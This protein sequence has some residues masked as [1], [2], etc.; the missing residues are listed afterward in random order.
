VLSSNLVDMNGKYREESQDILFLC[1]FVSRLWS[2]L[3]TPVFSLNNFSVPKYYY[4]YY[5]ISSGSGTWS[6]QP[7]EYN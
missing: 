6:T 1:R 4:Y 7:R 5:R 3:I 2:E